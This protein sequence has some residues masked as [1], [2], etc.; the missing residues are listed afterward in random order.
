MFIHIYNVDKLHISSK[1]PLLIPVPS[2]L[3]C[4][5]NQDPRLVGIATGKI[6]GYMLKIA[7]L[8]NI[9]LT[10]HRQRV[11]KMSILVQF[12]FRMEK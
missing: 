4:K 10:K 3:T 11:R 9:F 5:K 8:E 7:Q 12:I 2:H 6:Y 1:H